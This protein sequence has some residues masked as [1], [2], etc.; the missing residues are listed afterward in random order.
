MNLAAVM[1]IIDPPTKALK[2]SQDHL[3][4]FRS[5]PLILNME[6]T[7]TT[8]SRCGISFINLDYRDLLSYSIFRMF[9]KSSVNILIEYVVDSRSLIKRNF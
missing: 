7:P 1:M 3:N 8:A 6:P 2:G 4:A 9:F 5:S